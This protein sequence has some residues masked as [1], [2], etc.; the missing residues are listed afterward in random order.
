M[1]DLEEFLA[2]AIR[3]RRLEQKLTKH[4][5][6]RLREALGWVRGQIEFHGLNQIGPNR[7]ERLKI[8]R[9][10]VEAYM[11]EQYAT[12]LMRTMQASEVMNDFIDQQLKLARQVVVST[13]GVTTGSLTAA[14]VLPK[15]FE[16][17]IVNG[18]PW[19]ELLSDRLPRSVADKVSRMLGL[20]PDDV[21]KVFADAV[22]RPTERHV[23]AIIT[24]GVQ[25][26]GSI[27]QQL[28]WQIETSPAW[29]EDN[30][31]VWSAM[32]DS[33]VCATC[34]GLDGKRFPMDYVKV[35]P[36]PNCRCVLLP[37]SFFTQDRPARGDGG[38]TVDIPTTKKGVEAWL[39]QNPATASKI[40]GKKRSEAF[41][42]GKLSLDAAIKAA[43]GT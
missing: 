26:T 29:Q 30:E 24:T 8:L 18:V 41:V 28:L 16:Q 35:S 43:G 20:F 9:L 5:L 40:L 37:E 22:I 15:A 38:N 12:P 19:G 6:K 11:R 42:A 27:A 31:Q 13:G 21:G 25:D 1:T 14:A 32:L 2:L 23:E 36:H 34:M 39:R 4:A 33:A 17:V 3:Q 10:E 7:A